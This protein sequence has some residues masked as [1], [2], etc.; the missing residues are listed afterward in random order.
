MQSRDS[1]RVALFTVLMFA[2][3]S[4]VTVSLA[5]FTDSAHD[6]SIITTAASFDL[7]APIVQA[8]VISKVGPYLPG[9]IRQAGTYHVYANVSEAAPPRAACWPSPPT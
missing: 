4:P 7:P 1:L 2:L 9:Y 5:R 6:V 8:S 3:V